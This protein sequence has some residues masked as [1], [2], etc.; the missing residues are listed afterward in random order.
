MRGTLRKRGIE[1]E[2]CTR[3]ARKRRKGNF[4]TTYPSDFSITFS[5]LIKCYLSTAITFPSFSP[6]KTDSLLHLHLFIISDVCRLKLAT[7]I[8]LSQLSLKFVSQTA[9]DF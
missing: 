1:A 3:L 7:A 6:R 5:F 4:K 9:V 2:R 8:G